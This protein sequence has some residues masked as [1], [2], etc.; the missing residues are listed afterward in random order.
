[1]A[2]SFRFYVLGLVSFSIGLTACVMTVMQGPLL[3]LGPAGFLCVVWGAALMEGVTWQD[4]KE[5]V[6]P[7]F[8][9]V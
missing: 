2:D 3:I 1:M 9:R 5:Y 6:R 8:H 7:V 4:L